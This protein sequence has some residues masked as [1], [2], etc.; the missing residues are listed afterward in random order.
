MSE[1]NN[2]H[3]GHR[4]RL[5]ERFILEGLDSF[6]DINVLELLLFYC[7]QRRDTNPLAHR[8]M[9]RFGNVAEVLKATPSEL[10]QVDGVTEHIAT[11][12]SLLS[13]V[14]RRCLL[15][16]VSNY[17][18]L[19]TTEDCC[20]YLIP[21]FHGR[22]FE[23]VFLLCLDAKCKVLC[24]KQVAEGNVHS[25]EISIRKIAEI[26]L[27]SN[28]TSAVLAH[29]HP[30][31][32]AIPSPADEEMTIRLGRVLKSMG[33]ILADH[34]IVSGNDAVSIAQSGKYSPFSNDVGDL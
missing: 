26:A 25:T 21:Y 11:Y 17:K 23:T 18:I 7:V 9:D 28:A 19:Q 13:S 10:M 16:E 2:I 30:S 33:I 22:K 4:K 12:L 27:N 8:L 5:K 3:E 32:L 29:N 1:K 20:K 15:N 31:G 6:N 14:S 34:I 24:C